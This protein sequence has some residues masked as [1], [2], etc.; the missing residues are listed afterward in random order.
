MNKHRG[1]KDKNHDELSGVFVEAGCSVSD[2]AT[3]GVDD[4]PDVIVGCIGLNHLVEYKN[5]ETRYGRSG[6]NAGQKVFAR[7]WRGGKVWMVSTRDEAL[8]L[9]QNWRRHA[10][11]DTAGDRN[12]AR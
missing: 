4:F 10:R 6:L 2:M 7:D 9:V 1:S 12:D 8:A 3:C 5:P 11:I